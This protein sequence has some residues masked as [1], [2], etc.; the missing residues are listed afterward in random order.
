MTITRRHAIG[1]AAAVV[2]AGFAARAPAQ[3]ITKNARIVVGFPPGGSTDVMAHLLAERMRGVYAPDVSVE[4]KAGASGRVGAD[5]VKNGA[6]DGSQ[7]LLTPCSVLSLY[8]H[9][10]KRLSY[11]TLRDFTPVAPVGAV[12]FGLSV[13]PAV[14]ATVKSLADYFKWAKSDRKNAVYAS[15][16]AGAAPHFVGVMLGRAAGVD[17]DHV[18]YDGGAP[19]L[20]DLMRGQIPASVN[21]LS[22]VIP[23]VQTGKLRVLATSGLQRSPFLPDVP[24]FAESGFQEAT[25][26]EVFGLFVPSKTPADVVAKLNATVRDIANSKE[27]ADAM[28]KLSYDRAS[29]TPAEF[30]KFMKTELGRWEVVVKASGF[31]RYVPQPAAATF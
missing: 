20:Q 27:F 30:A 26:Q 9:V 14:P 1:C 6:A 31:D 15:P 28:A 21:V 24:T 3:V 29:D 11:D 17:L 13:G 7:M 4:N 18:A 19:A 22:E 23:Q 25:A 5:A 12:A 10:Y 16:A 2:L 8:P